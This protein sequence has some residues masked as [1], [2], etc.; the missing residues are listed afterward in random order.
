MFSSALLDTRT[1]LP[2]DRAREKGTPA[3][4]EAHELLSVALT[5]RCASP[6]GLANAD[7]DCVAHLVVTGTCAWC[8]ELFVRGVLSLDRRPRMRPLLGPP[9]QVVEPV[10]TIAG[11]RTASFVGYGPS[12][13]AAVSIGAEDDRND[14][15]VEIR[16]LARPEPPYRWL[17]VSPLAPGD[18]IPWTSRIPT[19]AQQQVLSTGQLPAGAGSGF[20]AA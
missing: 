11:I 20:L 1:R 10:D 3:V 17:G 19:A 9:P 15:L 16:K 13:P 8:W 12:P 4:A 5:R 7:D 14:V 18:R 6:A 2:T